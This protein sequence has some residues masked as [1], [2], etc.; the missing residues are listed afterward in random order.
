MEGLSGD[1]IQVIALGCQ[2][3]VLHAHSAY[4]L[5]RMATH[6]WQPWAGGI[7]ILL[8]G[9]GAMI[10]AW[11]GEA[12]CNGNLIGR[13]MRTLVERSHERWTSVYERL[14]AFA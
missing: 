5:N 7:Y 11:F 1:W 2:F 13:G 14:Q 6:F 3:R 12:R 4:S 8:A 9:T 10:R